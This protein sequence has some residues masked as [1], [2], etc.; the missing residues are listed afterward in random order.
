MCISV[1]LNEALSYSVSLSFS[2]IGTKFE[3]KER[4]ER[5]NDGRSCSQMLFRIDVLKYFAIFMEKHLVGVSFL[6]KMYA[7]SIPPLENIRKTSHFLM[8]SEGMKKACELAAFIFLLF[9][10][11]LN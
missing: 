2:P 1:P 7:F 8:F 3:R 9:E 11:S 6:T 10:D 5:Q 4:R